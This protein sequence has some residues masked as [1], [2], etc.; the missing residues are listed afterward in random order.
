[1][2]ARGL[3]TFAYRRENKLSSKTVPIGRY[4]N[5]KV[6]MSI[7]TSLPFHR[8]LEHQLFI[9]RLARNCQLRLSIY[10]RRGRRCSL[11]LRELALHYNETNTKIVHQFISKSRFSKS[12]FHIVCCLDNRTWLCY[13]LHEDTTNI[14][15][16]IQVG[17]RQFITFTRRYVTTM[18]SC[19]SYRLY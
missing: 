11:V 13:N 15:N 10:S 12:T 7:W 1:M 9:S 14:V 2:L 18:I 19:F 17:V 4:P 3:S 5:L 16:Y 8:I 6:K